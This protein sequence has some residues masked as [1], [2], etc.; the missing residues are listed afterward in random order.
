MYIYTYIHIYIYNFSHAH[1]A[2]T[3]KVMSTVEMG[4]CIIQTHKNDQC[5]KT[6]GNIA[7]ST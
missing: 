5:M 4:P 7:K 1:G 6:Y 3:S 2:P